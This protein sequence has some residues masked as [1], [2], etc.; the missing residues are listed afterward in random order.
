MKTTGAV[1]RAHKEHAKREPKYRCILCLVH[2][3]HRKLNHSGAEGPQNNKKKLLPNK[4]EKKKKRPRPV[5]SGVR[6]A[7]MT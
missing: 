1:C 3:E 7:H 6:Y 5:Y 4:H 2:F